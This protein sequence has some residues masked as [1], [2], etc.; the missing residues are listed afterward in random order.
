MKFKEF[1]TF[2]DADKGKDF[3]ILN[4]KT[5]KG[6]GAFLKVTGPD[7]AIYKNATDECSRKL[8]PETT[9]LEFKTERLIRCTLG[10]R[11]IEEEEGKEMKFSEQ[12]LREFFKYNSLVRDQFLSILDENANFLRS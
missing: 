9:M 3:E 6:T 11:G 10:W 8:T 4:P 5:K 12:N 1:D 7:S 2:T